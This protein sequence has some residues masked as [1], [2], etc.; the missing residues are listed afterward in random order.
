MF[1]S[2]RERQL[3]N[4]L[5]GG[6]FDR[7]IFGVVWDARIMRYCSSVPARSYKGRKEEPLDRDGTIEDIKSFS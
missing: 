7:D 1:S 3:S 5:S 4:M 6:D 2:K